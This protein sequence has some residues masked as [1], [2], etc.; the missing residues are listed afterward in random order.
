MTNPADL[1]PYKDVVYIYLGKDKGWRVQLS[2]LNCN[3]VKIWNLLTVH[4]NNTF[5]YLERKITNETLIFDG[6]KFVEFDELRH[7]P[8]W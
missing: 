5:H 4:P 6:E 2:V 1:I 7:T 3:R 8:E